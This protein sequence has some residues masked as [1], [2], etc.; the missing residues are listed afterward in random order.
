MV[1]EIF[2]FTCYRE[3]I[4]CKIYMGERARR[5]ELSALAKIIPCQNSYLSRVMSGESDLSL[6]QADNVGNYFGLSSDENTYFLTLVQYARAGSQSL[7]THF[8]RL[9]T[10]AQEERLNLQKRVGV[11]Q[12][13]SKVDQV[14]YYSLW[15]YAAVHVMTGIPHLQTKSSIARELNLPLNRVSEILEFLV[16]TG[17]VIKESEERYM[18]GQGQIHLKKNSQM[19]LRHHANWRS[20]AVRSM[21]NDLEG[22]IHYSVLLNASKKDTEILRG[23]IAK[24]I[25]DF[26]KVVHPSQ[27]EEMNCLIIDFFNPKA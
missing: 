12:T 27:D 24:F 25:E 1:K 9:I 22:G 3:F 4:K 20:Q 15:Y 16:S 7:R 17:L 2:S 10:E 23:M 5:G 13:L 19:I 11:R 6:E 8:K 18:T 14:T 21:E 26:M